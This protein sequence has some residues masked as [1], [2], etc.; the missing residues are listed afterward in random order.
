MQEVAS[1]S[2]KMPMNLK[3][4]RIM[5]NNE[6]IYRADKIFTGRSWLANQAVVVSDNKVA[7]LIAGADAPADAMHCHII[8]P[9]FI[10]IQIYG[11]HGKLLAVY[12]EAD[13]LFK[14]QDYCAKGGAPFF[15]PTVATNE[16]RVFF[17]CIDAVRD[18]W[19]QGGRGC[20]GLHV[21]GPWISKSKKGAHIESFIH[22]PSIAEAKEL[23]EYGKGVITMITL[24]PEVCSR[25]VIELVQSY[26][27]VVSA[28]HSSATYEEATAAFDRGIHAAT[29]LFNAMSPLQ[30]RSPGMVA[31]IFDH[32]A[33]MSSIVPDGY[34]VDFTAVRIA[35]KMMKER[36]FVITDA[37]TETA[38]GAYP[39]H[40]EGDRYE[41]NGILSGSALTMIK[42]VRN[43]VDKAGISLDE[44]LRMVSL[45]PAQVMNLANRIGTITKGCEANLVMI[46]NN[47][48]VIITCSV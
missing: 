9:A 42:S 12:P 37:V 29:H 24:A 44:A 47:L 26:G 39:H 46:D 21:E 5:A 13:S 19:Q 17:Q 38:S 35:K 16:T 18:Y 11:A 33:V 27:V 45:Y 36:L 14:L 41:S 30:H 25:E 40:L 10:D 20:I 1:L 32:P 43:L 3:S 28:G 8:A 34:H 4:C 23:L 22:S 6:T 2:G 7:E 15:Q 48:E 31:A